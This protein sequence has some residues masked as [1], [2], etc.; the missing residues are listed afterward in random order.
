MGKDQEVIV[1][2]KHGERP[3]GATD[4]TGH[5]P[6]N[7]G[8]SELLGTK[9]KPNFGLGWEE[10]LGQAPSPLSKILGVGDS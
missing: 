6:E 1:S 10:F 3:R 9:K 5:R 8:P 4:S 7:S 2:P